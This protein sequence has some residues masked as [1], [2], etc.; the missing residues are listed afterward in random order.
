MTFLEGYSMRHL[1]VAAFVATFVALGLAGCKGAVTMP[2]PEQPSPTPHELLTGTWL[3][4]SDFVEDGIQQTEKLLLTFIG[5]RFIESWARYEEG[6]L[7]D[8]WHHSGG[9]SITESTITKRWADNHDDDDSTPLAR[10]SVV[11]EYHLVNGALLV[12]HWWYDDPTE[13][14]QRFERA[15][16]PGLTAASLVG[17]WHH[18][19]P[20]PDGI[21]FDPEWTMTIGADGTWSFLRRHDEWPFQVAGQ[22]RFDEATYFATITD[23]METHLD[24]EGNEVAPPETVPEEY[25]RIGFAPAVAGGV[26]ASLYWDEAPVREDPGYG[27]Y[28]MHLRK[29]DR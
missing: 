24:E 7:A 4:S 14:F 17:T 8:T 29:V 19:E 20:D 5:E 15:A 13:S 1:Q 9:W 2:E 26:M 12:H 23:M 10:G 11:K 16:D 28:W 21:E 22:I 25:W 6:E 18:F 27:N 3:S